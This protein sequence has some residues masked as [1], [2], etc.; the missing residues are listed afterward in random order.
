[1][2]NGRNNGYDWFHRDPLCM[3]ILVNTQQPNRFGTIPCRFGSEADMCG[4]LRLRPR[5]DIGLFPY[6]LQ[7]RYGAPPEETP[8][9]FQTECGSDGVRFG[10]GFARLFRPV[11]LCEHPGQYNARAVEAPVAP[12]CSRSLGKRLLDSARA[13]ERV[14]EDHSP[15]S[16]PKILRT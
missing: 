6:R 8:D 5:A 7:L 16:Q 4:A 10:Q 1:K 15:E 12:R 14:G 9:F 13:T 3:S 11:E 2:H